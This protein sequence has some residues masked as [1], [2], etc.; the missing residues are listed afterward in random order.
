MK[1]IQFVYKFLSAN[2]LQ[3]PFVGDI[4]RVNIAEASR[5]PKPLFRKRPLLRIYLYSNDLQDFLFT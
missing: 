4:Q 2:R 5:D 1:W 3:K